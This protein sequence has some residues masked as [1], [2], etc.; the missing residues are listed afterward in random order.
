MLSLNAQ[1]IGLTVEID[2]VFYEATGPHP[3]TPDL[4]LFEDLDGYV[5]YDVYANLTNETD[6][7]IAIYSDVEGLGVAPM[8]I[9]APCGCFNPNFGAVLLGGSQN[10]A[11]FYA[12]PEI[13]YDTYWTIDLNDTEQS[14]ISNPAYSY[15]S[16]CSEIVEDGSIFVLPD[17]ANAAGD[18]LRIKIARV[19]TCGGFSLSACFNVFVGGDNSNVQDY[20]IDENGSGPF[21]VSEGGIYGCTDELALNF[22]PTA[23]END[24][25]CT[26]S[27]AEYCGPGTIWDSATLRCL[28]SPNNCGAGTYWNQLEAQCLPFD[29]CPEDLDNDG[30]VAVPDL[31]ILLSAYSEECPAV[32][33]CTDM[34]A[35][36]FNP[37][38]QEDDGSCILTVLGCTLEAA[39]NYNGLANLDDG[40][41]LFEDECGVC[42]GGGLLD[43]A[44]DC[45]GNFSVEF[46]DCDGEC[47]FDSDGDGVCDELEVL[48]CTDSD[49]A[50]FD[51]TATDDDGSCVIQGCTFPTACNYNPAADEDDGTCQSFDQC[52][53]CGGSGFPL[54]TCNCEG[55]PPDSGYDCYGE[56][57]NDIDGDGV[58]DQFEVI[59]CDDFIACN[60]QANA[61]DN[62]G[63][64]VFPDE[65]Y[66]C[67]GICLSDEDG[68]GVCDELEVGGCVDAS[69]CN[70]SNDA[71]DD[72]GSC[73]YAQEFY[74]CL[75][76]CLG[77]VD[78]DGV[79]DELEVSGCTDAEA[80]NYDLQA[81]DEDGS[82]IFSGCTDSD[83]C[84][85]FVGATIDD[86]SCIYSESY[87]TCEG[88]CI[89][90]SD[91]DGV[92]D[93]LE[94]SGCTDAEAFN[95]EQ[96]ATE[97][98]GSCAYAGCT[99]SI[100]CNYN[101]LASL[102]DDSCEFY[103]PGCTDDGACNY[104]DG[105]I[106]D[107]GTCLF[108]EDLWGGTYFDCEGNCAADLDGDGVCDED[109]IVG[110]QLEG[111][112]NYLAGATDEG[113]CEYESCVGCTYEFA[114]NYDP[115]F[116]I[117]DYSACEFG[118]CP[119][120]TD[121][122]ACNFNPTVTEDDG[123]CLEDLD[124]DGICD[125]YEIFGCNNENA[126]N[127]DSNA[128]EDDGSCILIGCS[129]DFACNYDPQVSIPEEDICIFPEWEQF[130]TNVTN[131][132]PQSLKISS[133]GT[134]VF[135]GSSSMTPMGGVV[136]LDFVEGN[137]LQRG[138]TIL[139]T[140]GSIG[141]Q[142]AVSGDGN[143]VFISDPFFDDPVNG[144]NFGKVQCFQW[145]DSTWVQ[146]GNS[147]TGNVMNAELGLDMDCSVDGN[148]L[149]LS[150]GGGTEIHEYS[151][152]EWQ[153]LAELA[154][155]SGS[156][157]K[158]ALSPN[159]EWA[160]VS[161]YP[162]VHIYQESNGFQLDTILVGG[163]SFGLYNLQISDT[164]VIATTGIPGGGS[165][166]D[167]G[168]HAYTKSQEGVWVNKG[169]PITSVSSY[170]GIA[171]HDNGNELLGHTQ[172]G[173]MFH[174][175]WTD[176]ESW[177]LSE[178]WNGSFVSSSWNFY[179]GK[180]LLDFSNGQ[181]FGA[182]DTVFQ[183]QECD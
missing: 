50:N 162:D 122:V 133:D 18:D 183:I 94:V 131:I 110:C 150:S 171:L 75:E 138:D 68:D 82:C 59:G 52:G 154:I 157:R 172:N 93:E 42:G 31:L 112:C 88:L 101:P 132:E 96:D 64:C 155:A 146:L 145:E 27:G 161:A 109:E 140:W 176:E 73:F 14:L 144:P 121:P 44:C 89:S 90:D 163:N 54:G 174:F 55:T 12:F 3:T 26:Y 116:S 181:N 23:F 66:D 69:A 128:T 130:G 85:F 99:V 179:N 106:Q 78:G 107:D 134:T 124:G 136:C 113:D 175:H 25:S 151:Q 74:D 135:L 34:E 6:E 149:I 39:C 61:T 72:D 21:F 139:G 119:G 143:R 168:L 79:C 70:Y 129:D 167:W 2:T 164:P 120:C 58:C 4:L 71:T 5:T 166:S 45:E 105:A 84:N 142:I 152:F 22:D 62:D 32:L 147:I 91:Q 177:E 100:A 165:S 173:Q 169:L 115:S 38:A 92:C 9:D 56:C 118:T 29:N 111:A 20:C 156:Y 10:E 137:W 98:D 178:T 37:N 80:D 47:L 67:D 65:F 86:G 1:M 126:E 51:S 60:Y 16:M 87:Y 63:S 76:T 28:P 17:N 102:D 57:L 103:C 46:Y 40:T 15:A 180:E 24:G 48:G 83:A 114:C 11:F 104:D 182:F 8:F 159:G 148:R 158:C 19:T 141:A 95:F 43:G 170:L 108:P 36:N 30:N 49:A 33:G 97:D 117:A 160:A 127:F 77:D 81:T 13:E 125:V 41:C 53:V 123:S 35:V 153:L 7:I